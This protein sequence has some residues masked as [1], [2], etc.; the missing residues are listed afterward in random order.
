VAVSDYYLDEFLSPISNPGPAFKKKGKQREKKGKM[1]NNIQLPRFISV[2]AQ[3]KRAEVGIR[4]SADADRDAEV[5]GRAQKKGGERKKRLVNCGRRGGDV[6]LLQHGAALKLRPITIAP[7]LKRERKGGKKRR[8]AGHV[9]EEKKRKPRQLFH[10]CSSFSLAFS[11]LSPPGQPLHGA[12]KR[13]KRKRLF[14]RMSKGGGAAIGSIT[15]ASS[16]SKVRQGPMG[17]ER[18]S[19]R[20]EKTSGH[21]PG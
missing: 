18:E 2:P 7:R 13:R 8:S 9:P 10:S 21:Q 14:W 5:G 4:H 17:Q 6:A 11:P 12:T 15:P 16:R 19:P 20:E 3:R 1:R